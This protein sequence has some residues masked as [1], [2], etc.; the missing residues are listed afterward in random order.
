MLWGM[1]KQVVDLVFGWGMSSHLLGPRGFT[2]SVLTWHKTLEEAIQQEPRIDRCFIQHWGWG[3]CALA[4]GQG[5][6]AVFVQL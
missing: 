6:H 1:L 3:S 2:A 5:L 4:A